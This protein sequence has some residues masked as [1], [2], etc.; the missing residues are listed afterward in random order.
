MAKKLSHGQEQASVTP[1]APTSESFVFGRTKQMCSSVP[2]NLNLFW[3]SA[4]VLCVWFLFI[5]TPIWLSS[6]MGKLLDFPFVLHLIG[7]IGIYMACVINS[8]I[9]PSWSKSIH[10]WVGRVGLVCGYVG[11]ALGVCITWGRP[12][13]DPSFGIPITVGGV[14]QMICQI[15]GYAAIKKYQ[16]VKLKLNNLPLDTP[17]GAV[18]ALEDQRTAFLMTHIGFMLGLFVCACGIPAAMRLVGDDSG[19]GALLTAIAALNI[20][21]MLYTYNF[22]AQ[23]RS[24]NNGKHVANSES[25]ALIQ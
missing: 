12:G 15:V 13:V 8:L 5:H 25:S 21:S 23:I 19:V 3:V 9:T 24:K 17:T 4:T 18:K 10:V 16:Q 1:L 20:L 14:S 6:R 22:Y 7:V 11:F 2:K